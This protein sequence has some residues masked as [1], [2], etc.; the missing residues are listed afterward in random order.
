MTSPRDSAGTPVRHFKP[1]NRLA[2]MI[3]LPGGK[4]VQ[5]A[6]QAAQAAVEHYRPEVVSDIDAAIAE[7]ERLSTRPAPGAPEHER[8]YRISSSVL[9]HAGLFDLE[10]VGRAA[11]SLCELVDRMQERGV[12]DASAV[13][14]HVGS[15]RLLREMGQGDPLQRA[16][17]LRGLAAVVAKFSAEP[18]SA[19]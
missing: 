14:V 9:D 15:M 18:A 5:E 3:R 7:L 2:S 12:W 6:I 13:T 8:V 4:T 10:D 16:E 19:A 11:Y 17:L 1:T